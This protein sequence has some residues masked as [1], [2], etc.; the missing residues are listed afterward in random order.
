[1]YIEAFTGLTLLYE[2]T[3]RDLIYVL[4]QTL[5]PDTS[6]LALGEATILEM[7]GFRVR[8]GERWNMK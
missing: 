5:T 2:L 4:G 8:Q 1:M 7:N 3:W 6:A